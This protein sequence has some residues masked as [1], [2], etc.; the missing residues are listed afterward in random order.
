MIDVVGMVP[1]GRL[2]ITDLDYFRIADPG[3]SPLKPEV[4]TS[5][6]WQQFVIVTVSCQ[7]RFA[8]T[9]GG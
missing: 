9:Q 8:E 5:T 6:L 4:S 3:V 2:V 1:A 7:V